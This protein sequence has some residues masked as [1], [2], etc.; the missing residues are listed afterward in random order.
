M[1][2]RSARRLGFVGFGAITAVL[3]L[4]S[5]A[6]GCSNLAGKTTI[7]GINGTTIN[8]STTY[9]G[10]GGAFD[11]PNA[12][13][14]NGY[15][16][17]LPTSRT[18]VNTLNTNVPGLPDISLTI[19]P[20]TCSTQIGA[21]KVNAAAAGVW[22]VRFVKAETAIDTSFPNPICHF[23]ADASQTGPGNPTS[24]WVVIGTMN[25]DSTGNG[26]GQYVLPSTM[27]GPGNICIDKSAAPNT[28][29]VTGSGSVVPPIVFL[30]LI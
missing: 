29:L 23:D 22:E 25:V 15:C 10:N 24:R 27:V 11:S 18:Q 13:D 4:S 12:S 8:G 26:T 21:T 19:A 30:N 6:F 7:T 20:Y 1:Q 9:Y 17:G 28:S 16:G 3:A 14:K 2:D 5:A